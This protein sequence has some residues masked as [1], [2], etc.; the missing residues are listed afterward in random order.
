MS[1]S[2]LNKR[3]INCFVCIL[4][5][6]CALVLQPVVDTAEVLAHLAAAELIHLA[7]Y[8]VQEIAVVADE[9]DCSFECLQGFLEH[10]LAAHVEVVGR[11]V[12]YEQVNRFEQQAD[13]CQPAALTAGEH[14]HAFVDGFAAEHECT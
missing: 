12:E 6:C 7:H 14:F 11:L 9:Y 8:T 4:Q 3:Q 2:G 5:A 1:V 10:V 13:H